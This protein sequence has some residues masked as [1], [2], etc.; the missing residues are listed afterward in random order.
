IK[1][2]AHRKKKL[3]DQYVR[4]TT[5]RRNEGRI[6]HIYIHPNT[7]PVITIVYK[8]NNVK[9]FELHKV[10]TFGDF[11]I[12]EW[13]ELGPSP[14]T[15]KKK[16]VLDMLN[17]LNN[18][19]SKFKELAKSLNID[20]SIPLPLQDPSIPKQKKRKTIELELKIYVDPF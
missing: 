7:R 8:N 13:D 14:R 18:R 11:G 4:I 2:L 20:E 3:Y 10:F 17:S 6:T 12:S 15:K 19:Y 1:R 16:V 5:K 9:D